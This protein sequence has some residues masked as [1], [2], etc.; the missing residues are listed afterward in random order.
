[1]M[2]DG[3]VNLRK[4]SANGCFYPGVPEIGAPP[5][6]PLES[7]EIRFSMKQTIQ[8]WGYPIYGTPHISASFSPFKSSKGAFCQTPG[9]G[10]CCQTSG[11]GSAGSQCQS[12]VG[13]PP[14]IY[15]SCRSNNF[16]NHSEPSTSQLISIFVGC[17][18]TFPRKNGWFATLLWIESMYESLS[19]I[20][21]C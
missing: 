9:A 14:G 19:G 20:E 2:V 12:K 8:L 7:L 6:H 21:N 16:M 15:T 11:V 10:L 1:M 13:I 18:F 4:C 17:M 3:F 5:N